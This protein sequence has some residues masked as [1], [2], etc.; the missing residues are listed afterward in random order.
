M[1][2]PNKITPQ[3]VCGLV[4]PWET[5][6][7]W[8]QMMSKA[9]YRGGLVVGDLLGGR[10]RVGKLDLF[11]E[12]PDPLPVVLDVGPPLLPHSDV[13]VGRVGGRV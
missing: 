7:M 10:P 8:P 13:D 9:L 11:P 5:R 12:L 4:C 1:G 3:R 2:P 6:E